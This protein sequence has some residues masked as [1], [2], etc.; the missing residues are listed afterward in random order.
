MKARFSEKQLYQ[1]L[2]IPLL[3]AAPAVCYNSTS[4]H[5]DALSGEATLASIRIGTRGSQLA[6]WQAEWVAAELTRHGHAVELITIATRGDIS[7]A[8]LRDVGGQGLFTKEIQRAVL[9]QQVDLAVH[10]LKD[11]PTLP[12]DGLVLAAVPPRETTA[13]CLLSRSGAGFEQLPAG[14]TV[15][16]GSARRGAQLLAWRPDVVIADIRGNVESRIRKMHEGQFDAIIL[17]AAGL[18]RLQLTEQVTQTLP[19][20]KILPAI[21]QGAL[22]LECREEDTVTRLAVEQLNCPASLAAVTAERSLL[23][24]LLAGCLAPVAGLGQVVESGE[25]ELTAGVF[26]VDGKSAVRGKRRGSQF[27]AIEI[28]AELAEELKRQGAAELIS[29][30]R[31]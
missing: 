16:T 28:G 29:A 20:S 12:I 21:G 17:A 7:T 30:A 6:R 9:S 10:S 15:G 8:S 24:S 26:S 1:W 25:L 3:L 27:E 4:Q 31:C 11:L 22:G 19:L 2:P 23:L 5:V 18:T 13:D 14:A